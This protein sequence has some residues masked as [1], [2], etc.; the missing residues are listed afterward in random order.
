[1]AHNWDV[2]CVSRDFD[3]GDA[4][5][6]RFVARHEHTW[7]IIVRSWIVDK[8]QS[9]D[10]RM[11]RLNA[12]EKARTRPLTE[13]EEM[14]PWTMQ[15]RIVRGV[16]HVDLSLATDLATRD[17]KRVG[18]QG[19]TRRMLEA[20]W[21]RDRA[22]DL[23]AVG[24]PY[25]NSIYSATRIEARDLRFRTTFTIRQSLRTMVGR[26]LT[27]ILATGGFLWISG[28]LIL[29]WAEASSLPGIGLLL[30]ALTGAAAA[31]AVAFNGG[32]IWDTFHN[33]FLELP[34]D[35]VLLDMGRALLAALHDCSLVS[36][37]LEIDH[38]HVIETQAGGYEIFV[39]TSSVEDPTVAREP[40]TPED[41]D[42]FSRAFEQMLGPL[43]N[44]RYLIERDSTSLRNPLY[45]SAWFLVR[46]TLRLDEHLKA[47]HRVPDILASRRERADALARHWRHYVGGGDLIY[48]RSVEGRRL[49]M[50]A[51]AQ[52]HEQIRQMRFQIWQ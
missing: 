8:A 34:A 22:Y 4:D 47:Y 40:V 19:Y 26:T 18:Y 13:R 21:E 48:T 9:L 25:D 12:P 36:T 23:W 35:N 42:T 33:A 49:L 39:G 28:A 10:D 6:R 20:V 30:S 14:V 32:R 37:D 27:S 11:D 51:R 31:L 16:A 17:F 52:Q 29:P 15:G 2:V 1:V 7:G 41:S 5:L 44:A 38:V 45:R 3:K 43:G 50:Q 24:Q 46:K